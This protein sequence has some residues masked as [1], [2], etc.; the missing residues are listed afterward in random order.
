MPCFN[1]ED[2][3]DEAINS[4]KAQTYKDWELVIFDD[5]S[6]DSTY[7]RALA[8][9]CENIKVFGRREHSGFIGKVKNECIEKLGNHSY[10]CHV[11]SDDKIPE[12]SLSIFVDYMNK[13]INVGACCGN[14][15][16]F[17]DEGHEWSFP[18]VANSGEYDSSILL[19]YNCLF[20]L[21]FYRAEIIRKIGY[22]ETISS[23]VDYDLA[24]RLDETTTIKRIKEPITYYYRQHREQVSTRAREEQNFNAKTALTEALKRRGIQ[25]KVINNAPPFRVEEEGHFIWGKK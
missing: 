14:F 25:G 16:C 8:Y 1:V 11:G 12:D 9:R 7:E 10:L 24:L 2:Y 4:I 13:N 23:A 19:R 17:D 22:N 21:R 15:M 5:R 20:P 3:I 18:H 6:T